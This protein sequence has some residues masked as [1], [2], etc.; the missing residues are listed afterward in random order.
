MNRFSNGLTLHSH[1]FKLAKMYSPFLCIFGFDFLIFVLDF[2]VPMLEWETK[3]KGHFYI[4]TGL[5][6]KIILVSQNEQ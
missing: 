4:L 3:I 6:A 1:T 5:G 2:T